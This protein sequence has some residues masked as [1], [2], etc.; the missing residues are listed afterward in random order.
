M[1][2]FD[3]AISEPSTLT[4]RKEASMRRFA[5]LFA[6][7]IVLASVFLLGACNTMEGVGEDVEGAGESIQDAAD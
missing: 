1:T 2:P 4:F 6:G 7:T 5:H 3:Q